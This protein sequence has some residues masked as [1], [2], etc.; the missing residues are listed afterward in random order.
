MELRQLEYFQAFGRLESMTRAAEQLRVSQPSISVAIKKLEEE[1]GISLVDRSHKKGTL[2][3]EGQIFLKRVDHVLGDLHDAV[4]EISDIQRPLG[5]ALRIGITPI[6][7]ALMFPRFLSA[8]QKLHPDVKVSIVEEGSLLIREQLENSE[9]DIALMITSDLPSSL[10]VL[11]MKSGQ[12]YVCLSRTNPLS[13]LERVPFDQLQEF[14]FILFKE[15]TFIRQRIL[16]ECARFHFSPRILFSSS[17]IGTILELVEQGMGITFFIQD[18]V[19]QRPD[20]VVLPL[21]EPLSLD[22]GL[23]WKKERYLSTA[24]QNFIESSQRIRG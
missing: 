13:R 11:P 5:G 20:L 21:A 19:P 12:I 16:A 10:E 24:A 14:E 1:L 7:G 15:D 4:V 2:T 9:L 8:Y 3:R 18:I 17:Q 6:M 22:V 23:A